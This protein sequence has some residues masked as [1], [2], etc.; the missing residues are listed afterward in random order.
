MPATWI[1]YKGKKILYVDY[2]GLK[3]MDK[4][5]ELLETAKQAG[6]IIRES[7]VKVLLLSDFRNSTLSPEF[8]ELMKANFPSEN[9]GKNAVLGIE[10]IKKLL[11]DS[12]ERAT[13]NIPK[14]FEDETE[15]KEF[16]IS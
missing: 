3:T 1:N 5:Y 13:G 12:F 7:K 9:V 2:R 10:G 15:A 6:Q 11:L 4:K 16:L 14:S 8:M